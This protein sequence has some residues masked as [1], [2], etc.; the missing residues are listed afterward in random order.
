VEKVKELTL[1][2]DEALLWW[3]FND[4]SYH[5]ITFMR[6]PRTLRPTLLP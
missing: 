6:K 2:V 3:N 4:Y 5:V 1:A